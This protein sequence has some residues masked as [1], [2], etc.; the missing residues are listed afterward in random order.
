[1]FVVPRLGTDAGAYWV[2]RVA[3]R[4]EAK[5]DAV[6]HMHGVPLTIAASLPPGRR[7]MLAQW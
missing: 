7:P 3:A 5:R 2:A 6:T 4:R 1:M